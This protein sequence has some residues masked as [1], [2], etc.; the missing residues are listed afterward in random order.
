MVEAVDDVVI[1][2]RGPIVIQGTLRGATKS[3]GPIAHGRALNCGRR[4]RLRFT[5]DCQPVPEA[6]ACPRARRRE[7]RDINLIAPHHQ[8]GPD[9]R[10]AGGVGGAGG[11]GGDGAT[12]S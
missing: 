7:R 3:G 5:G 6:R 9:P 2:C 11:R 4:R 10:G 8:R 12:L 1:E